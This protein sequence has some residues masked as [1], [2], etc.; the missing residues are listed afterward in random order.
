ML[1]REQEEALKKIIDGKFFN[2]ILLPGI[3]VYDAPT[4]V[5][6]SL[7]RAW[8]GFVIT[9]KTG[10]V[11]VF[12]PLTNVPKDK[13]IVLQANANNPITVSLSTVSGATYFG[14]QFWITSSALTQTF[15]GTTIANTKE[16]IALNNITLPS[17]TYRVESQFAWRNSAATTSL[18][19]SMSVNGAQVGGLFRQE[20]S[21][22]N[23][24]E[25]NIIHRVDYVAITGGVCSFRLAGFMSAAS[26]G[27]MNDRKLTIWRTDFS[28][29]TSG[30][31]GSST[32]LTPSSV[33]T[34]IDLYLF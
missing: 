31:G 13:F 3:R 29:G 15:S 12:A 33:N 22:T 5:A 2:G 27:S 9:N 1:S 6:H 7:G 23:V 34:L 10:S 18:Q 21:D 17:G 28:T 32:L 25:R 26:T 11:D 14:E 8:N 20:L 24:N 4:N 30:G 19:L 16:A